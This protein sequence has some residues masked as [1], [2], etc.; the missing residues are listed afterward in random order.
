MQ[1]G[2]TLALVGL[3]ASATPPLLGPSLPLDASLHGAN[4]DGVSSVKGYGPGPLRFEANHGQTASDVKYLARGRGYALLLTQA[5]ALLILGK[6]A[7]PKVEE[8]I[9]FNSPFDPSSTGARERTALRLR[10]V[11]ANKEAR[12]F[13]LQQQAGTANYLIGNN[14]R[15]W[16]ANIPTYAKVQY[17][18]VYPGVDLVYYGHQ[19]ILEYD[20]IVAPGADP[21]V[22]NLALE[23]ASGLD[24]D[25]EGN[26]RVRVAGG[27]FTMHRPVVYQEDG[28]IRRQVAGS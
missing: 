4:G 1:I 10:L 9:L 2:M 26:L 14:P 20:F 6:P 7:A 11:G 23:G 19:G 15:A 17:R 22:I 25:S 18:G 3:V 16:R 5:E 12:V 27:H 28:G 24:V 8:Q 13:G 21:T